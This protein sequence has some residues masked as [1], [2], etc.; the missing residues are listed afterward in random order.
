[1]VMPDQDTDLPWSEP[2]WLEQAHAWIHAEVERQGLH[3]RGA[4]EQPHVRPWSTVLRVPV[5]DGDLYFKAVAP[6]LA[7]EVPITAAL[8]HWRPDCM[9]RVLAADVEHGWMLM[10][11]GGTRLRDQIRADRDVRRWETPLRIYAETQIELAS[12]TPELL[13]MGAPDRRLAALPERY[14]QLLAGKETLRVGLPDGLTLE[15]YRRL[16]ELAPRVAALCADLASYGVP[17]SLHHGDFHDGNVF[18]RDG[19]PL[20]FDW[21]DCSVAH[22][23]FSLRTTFVSVEIS[24]DLEEG[25]GEIPA[26][27][28]AYLE[29]WTRFESRSN[30]QAA[31]WL[32]QRLSPVVSA[33]GWDRVVTSLP[34]PLQKEYAV[35]VPA[36][37]REFLATEAKP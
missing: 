32:A 9:P 24:L 18:V 1:M 2:G 11:D 34:P 7:H 35:P 30:L 20:F 16:Q 37:M 25:A 4:I 36:L 26:L 22:P 17:D 12:R 19:R 13:A 14:H 21:G 6:V 23:F 28:D 33:L 8:A 27:R 15:E 31:F 5:A 29:P 3:V 10:P